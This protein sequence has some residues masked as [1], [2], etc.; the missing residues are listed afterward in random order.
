MI[1]LIAAAI[2]CTIAGF[3]EP[4]ALP[5]PLYRRIHFGWLGVAFYLWSLVLAGRI[6]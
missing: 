3:L 6:H 2:F 5:A 1:L 4:V